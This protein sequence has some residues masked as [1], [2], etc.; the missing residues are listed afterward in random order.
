MVAAYLNT[1]SIVT[2]F[3]TSRVLDSENYQGHPSVD[4]NGDV[5]LSGN[6]DGN[7][8]NLANGDGTSPSSFHS[9]GWQSTGWGW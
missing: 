4:Q 6:G 7:G 2:A 1:H 9:V 8:G 3:S 5:N